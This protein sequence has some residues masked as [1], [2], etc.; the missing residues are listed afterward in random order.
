MVAMPFHPSRAFTVRDVQANGADIL[1][2][3]ELLAH[4]PM[5]TM[6]RSASGAP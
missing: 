6:T 1:R 3:T 5:A 2:Q 4:E